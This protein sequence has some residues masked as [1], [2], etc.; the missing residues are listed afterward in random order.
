MKTKGQSSIEYLTTYGW[1]L[2][3]VSIAT[4]IAYNTVDISCTQSFSGFYTDALSVNDYGTDVQ[5]Q[6]V[7][8]LTN[9][10]FQNIT[11]T[12]LNVSSNIEYKSKSMNELIRPGQSKQIELSGFTA[13]DSCTEMKVNLV[14]NKGSLSNQ[15]LS[16]AM[17]APIKMK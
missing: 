13:S 5:D 11:I 2:L 14:Y 17:K 6:F 3:A 10:R 16:A 7:L 4:G 15:K 1:M 12:K 8:S 9:Q